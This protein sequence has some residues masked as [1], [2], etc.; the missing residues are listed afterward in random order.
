MDGTDVND[1]ASHESKIAIEEAVSGLSSWLQRYLENPLR[2]LTLLETGAQSCTALA[3]VSDSL[4]KVV[5][6]SVCISGCSSLANLLS[7]LDSLDAEN[8]CFPAVYSIISGAR[9]AMAT[10][11]P[12]RQ[13]H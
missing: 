9:M 12:F 11:L 8:H 5:M 7:F 2:I 3:G 4:Q 1:E 13:N 6:V 10:H